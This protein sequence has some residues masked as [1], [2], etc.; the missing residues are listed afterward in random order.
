MCGADQKSQPVA[1][2]SPENNLLNGRSV[3]ELRVQITHDLQC[4]S[5]N[6]S[7]EIQSLGFMQR[8]PDC[9][10]ISLLNAIVHTHSANG[11]VPNEV[12]RSITTTL[13]G[14]VAN[15]ARDGRN[16]CSYL[17]IRLVQQVVQ[18]LLNDV[19]STETSD[20]NIFDNEKRKAFLR[21]LVSD[22][23]VALS[24]CLRLCFVHH[25]LHSL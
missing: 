22:N 14:A 15:A 19:D 13:G 11:S 2:V 20:T 6:G 18:P 24:T 17:D 4:R 5:H 10:A 7:I 23:Q 1:E 21:Q 25:L 12:F 9:A 8:N 3:E 16:D